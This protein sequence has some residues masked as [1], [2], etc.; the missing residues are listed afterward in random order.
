M[1]SGTVMHSLTIWSTNLLSVWGVSG[2]KFVDAGFSWNCL[3]YDDD[4]ESDWGD[5]NFTFS[6]WDLGT[7]NDTRTDNRNI[8]LDLLNETDVEDKAHS[9]LSGSYRNSYA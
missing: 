9:K 6:S 8:T 4:N 2:S 7:Y 5:E 3:V 1:S